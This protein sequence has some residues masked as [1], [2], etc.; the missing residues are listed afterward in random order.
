VFRGVE[1][2]DIFLKVQTAHPA[3]SPALSMKRRGFG[4][5]AEWKW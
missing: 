2:M 4:G 3:K 1:F 5:G